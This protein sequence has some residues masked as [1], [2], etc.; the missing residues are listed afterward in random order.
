MIFGGW[1]PA[2]IINLLIIF[3]AIFWC[4]FIHYGQSKR[5]RDQVYS[6]GEFINNDVKLVESKTRKN[7]MFHNS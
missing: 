7:Y 1:L 4:M 2:L 5:G 6:E 3:G